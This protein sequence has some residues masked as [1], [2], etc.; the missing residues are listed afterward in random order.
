[1]KRLLF[2]CL[3]I[4]Q[5]ISSSVFAQNPANWPSKPV[6]IVVPY[7]AAGGSDTLARIISEQL[8]KKFNQTFI[9]ENRPGAGGTIGSDF[10]A[11]SSPDGYTL[12]IS[13]VGSHVIAPF[14]YPNKYD[15]IKDFTHIAFLGGPPLAL[16]V[17]PGLPIND[18]KSFISYAKAQPNGLVYGSPGIGTHGH[19]IGQYFAEMNNISLEHVG[20]KGGG[21][22]V[23]DIAGGQLPAG[24]MTLTSAKALVLANKLR[25]IAVTSSKR[26][27]NFPNTPTFAELGYPK[28]TSTTWFSV[29]APAGLPSPIVEKLNLAINQ[30]MQTPA[31]KEKLEF[32]DLE[33]TPMSSREFNKY[34]QTEIAT[35]GPI[36]IKV[37]PK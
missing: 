16:V 9:V 28:L 19:I 6:K 11:K 7:A 14:Q 23:N 10:A 34:V 27:S 15:P 35:W 30:S 18:L 8:S 5:S 17:N 33:F 20:Y 31:A 26:L 4:A 12:V 13:G 29:S 25:L 3:L 32:D 22:V 37:L 2:I 24:I 36:A 1:M 21:S